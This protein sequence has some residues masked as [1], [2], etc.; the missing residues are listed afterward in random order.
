M[1]RVLVW[2]RRRTVDA[3]MSREDA[4]EGEGERQQRGWAKET[5]QPEMA[6]NLP[7]IRDYTGASCNG[8]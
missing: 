5:S 1:L 3:L 6:D 7:D 4:L 2:A 8:D